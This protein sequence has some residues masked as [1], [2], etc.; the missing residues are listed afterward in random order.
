MLS[1]AARASWLVPTVVLVPIGIQERLPRSVVPSP[2]LMIAAAGAAALLGLL[3]GAMVLVVTRR[4]AELST[5][6]PP[7]VRTDALV[8][9]V[10]SAIVLVV[11]AVADVSGAATMREAQRT[12]E[13]TTTA[14]LHDAPGWNGGAALGTTVIEASSLDRRTQASKVMTH[15]F[16][17]AFRVLLLFIDNRAGDHDVV[18]DLDSVRVRLAGGAVRPSLTRDELRAHLKSGEVPPLGTIR[19]PAGK[20][21]ERAETFFAEDITFRD[22]EAVELRIDG[23]PVLL[24]GRYFTV[25]EKRA[26]D[27]H[28]H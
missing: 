17:G 2:P 19:V 10:A 15:S 8:G 5:E 26:I 14:A 13:S 12:L 11:V 24:Q 28:A 20:R 25:P 21:F 23:A 22:A 9:T 27:A 6:L 16:D 18:V 1:A 7:A 3:L 4:T